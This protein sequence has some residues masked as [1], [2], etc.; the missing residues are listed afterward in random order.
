MQSVRCLSEKCRGEGTVERKLGRAEGHAATRFCHNQ[1]IRGHLHC[2]D[3]PWM[4][5]EGRGGFVHKIPNGARSPVRDE[6][7]PARSSKVMKLLEGERTLLSSISPAR[8]TPGW[9]GGRTP[10]GTL[11]TAKLHRVGTRRPR[12]RP[13]AAGRAREAG[14]KQL[15]PLH[16]TS[17]GPPPRGDSPLAP[18]PSALLSL[19][20]ILCF[21]PLPLTEGPPRQ[22]PCGQDGQ[23]QRLPAQQAQR[24][25]Q[26]GAGAD[27]RRPQDL[28]GGAEGTV[29]TALLP[30]RPSLNPEKYMFPNSPQK[31]VPLHI[32]PHGMVTA[33][34][35]P[36]LDPGPPA[37]RP[38]RSMVTLTPDS[39]RFFWRPPAFWGK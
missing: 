27:G 4:P 33:T 16:P 14:K 20:L 28:G 31:A 23:L 37:R 8:V 32:Q 30:R 10:P 18:A 25:P 9:G 38:P 2:R 15:R 11:T 12:P 19:D 21:S 22:D 36:A 1:A 39:P 29:G 24:A 34:P 35:K 6:K 7:P 3:P 13:G 5:G 26:R 17:P